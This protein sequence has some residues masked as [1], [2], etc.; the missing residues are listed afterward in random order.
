MYQ[1]KVD[2]KTLAKPITK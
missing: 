2:R 1:S